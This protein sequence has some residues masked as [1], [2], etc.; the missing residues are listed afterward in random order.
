MILLFQNTTRCPHFNNTILALIK[1][2]G[3]GFNQ[4][5]D[6][7]G[8][9]YPLI[10]N[11]YMGMR[12]G[13][14]RRNTIKKEEDTSAISFGNGLILKLAECSETELAERRWKLRAPRGIALS[15]QIN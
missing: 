9:C 8:V 12:N 6:N 13:S 14:T 2:A 1:I 7:R 4:P 3:L 5:T 10:R 11:D 15:G